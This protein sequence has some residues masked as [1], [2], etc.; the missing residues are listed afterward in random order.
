MAILN[1]IK[2]L[3]VE[4]DMVLRSELSNLFNKLFKGVV[5]GIDGEDGL[6]KFKENYNSDEKIDIVL[7]DINMP[8]MNG[9][10]MVK[11]IKGIDEDIPIIFLTAYSDKNFLLEALQ[12]HVSDYL[13]KPFNVEELF[14]KME[15]AYLPV[16]QKNLLE[17]KNKEL[18]LLNMQIKANAKKQINKLEKD[19]LHTKEIY[20][21]FNKYT[22]T[23]ETDMQGKITY[24]SKPFL[25][26]CGFGEDELL[27]NTHKAVKDRETP[28]ELYAQIWETIKNKKV[29]TGQMKNRKKDGSHYWLESVIFPVLDENNDIKGYKSIAV[30]ITSQKETEKIVSDLINYD[31]I[32]LEF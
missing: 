14:K 24:I 18:E 11:N 30:N 27:G 26:T 22:I 19:I 15:K 4:D 10:E 12:L 13:I 28:E 3:Y 17:S 6:E 1:N 25:D 21:L 7:S 23:S 29:W 32:E 2:L 5:T 20:D 16:Y 8:N 9:L 31:D